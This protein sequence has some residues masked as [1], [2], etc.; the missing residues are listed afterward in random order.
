MTEVA[1]TGGG[2]ANQIPGAVYFIDGPIE[3]L[4]N[5]D[6]T[7]NTTTTFVYIPQ[8]SGGAYHIQVSGTVQH[9]V[10][11]W[12]VSCQAAPSI[13]SSQSQVP[14]TS[15]GAFQQS[16]TLDPH[17]FGLPQV[18]ISDVSSQEGNSGTFEPRLHR[19]P[20]PNP[21]LPVTIDYATADGTATTAD[22]RL[23]G[24]KRHT[25]IHS[26]MG[27]SLRPSTLRSSGT[28]STSSTRRS[29]SI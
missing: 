5:L 23:S 11:M 19:Q 18:L 2:P 9:L 8:P 27:R 14:S 28:P 13:P 4:D 1:A 7:D 3:D 25:D 24:D 16:V 20:L 10:S 21:Q 26:G 17:V 15:A 22:H 29:S 12:R 6:D